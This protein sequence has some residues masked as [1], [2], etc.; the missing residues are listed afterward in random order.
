MKQLPVGCSNNMEAK[1]I[2]HGQTTARVCL[3]LRKSDLRMHRQTSS[4]ELNA[5]ARAENSIAASSC[6]S[7]KGRSKDT[8]ASIMGTK[9]RGHHPV[10]IV[11]IRTTTQ[12]IKNIR[13]MLGPL[14]TISRYL[15]NRAYFAARE[16][17]RLFQSQPEYGP[18]LSYRRGIAKLNDG[19][20]N[21][22]V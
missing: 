10:Y 17:P 15:V 3:T 4:L 13:S 19:K 22:S 16:N 6:M 18:R 1:A 21:R 11:Y 7:K 12:N 2:C 5:F 9:V 8:A 14:L 20:Q